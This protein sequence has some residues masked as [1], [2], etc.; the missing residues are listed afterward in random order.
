MALTREQFDALR[1][2][3]LSVEQIVK[4]EQGEKPS[5]LKENLSSRASN[6]K[7]D[8]KLAAQGEINPLQF[9]I[10]AAG[11]TA[12]ALG[13]ILYQGM[14]AVAPGVMGGLEKGIGKVAETEA[15][16][17]VYKKYADW[18]ARNPEQARDLESTLNI[19]SVLP[20]GKAGQLGGRVL[21]TGAKG[22]GEAITAAKP[23][24]GQAL[25]TGGALGERAGV[26]VMS[27]SLPPTIEQ[28]SR[29]LS[30][31][32]ANP[33]KERLSMAAKGIEQAPKTV[34]D[35]ANKYGLVGILRSEVGTRAKRL[36]TDLFENQ[37]KPALNNIAEKVTKKDIFSGVKTKIN[38]V[39]DISRRKALSKALS[40]VEQDYKK[41][42][43]WNYSTLDEIK[44]S[45]A[46]R[47]PTKVW[48]GQEI[49]G[50]VNEIRKLLSDE[51]RTTIRKKLP[52]PIKEIYDEY[53]SLKELSQRGAKALTRGF[54]SGILGMTS[55]GIRAAAFPVSTIGG[56]A[57]SKAGSTVKKLGQKLLK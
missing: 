18:A 30:Y 33:L 25:A 55:E 1:A 56:Y 50:D 47:L 3:G 48:K 10:R 17:N 8:I 44:S 5:G 49:A 11:E 22:A 46:G 16:Q 31:K 13:D 28:A 20:V 35:V 4:F 6:I 37:V 2:K 29:K 27:A 34:A 51:M 42:V 24:L 32:A 9:G 14:K 19:A 52:A 45:M 7:S 26:R 21:K 12:G 40:A 57:I 36:S 39:A 23:V 43:S 53:G 15:V 41:V 38:K 54:D